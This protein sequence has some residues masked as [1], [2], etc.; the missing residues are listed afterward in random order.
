VTI[1]IQK[2]ESRFLNSKRS[3]EV[4]GRPREWTA[5]KRKRERERGKSESDVVVEEE[6]ERKMKN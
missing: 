4:Q 2:K 3:D 6:S 1:A 5:R